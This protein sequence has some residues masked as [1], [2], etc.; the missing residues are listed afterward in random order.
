[1]IP[2]YEIGLDDQTG[3]YLIPGLFHVMKHLYLYEL[4]LIMT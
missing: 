2:S 4:L 1:M 3:P